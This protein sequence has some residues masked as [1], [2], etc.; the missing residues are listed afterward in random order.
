MS[1]NYIVLIDYTDCSTEYR[2]F[3]S[4][5][6]AKNFIEKVVEPDENVEYAQIIKAESQYC[7]S[8]PNCAPEEDF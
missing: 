8:N 4:Y 1:N 2:E 5:P 6:Q 3:E 7:W